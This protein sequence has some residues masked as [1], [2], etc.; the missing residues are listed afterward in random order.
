VEYRVVGHL[1]C[2]D[3]QVGAHMLGARAS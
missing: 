1:Q 2:V 3:D